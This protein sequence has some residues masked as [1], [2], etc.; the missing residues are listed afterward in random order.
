MQNKHEHIRK[1][2]IF[3]FPPGHLYLSFIFFIFFHPGL[4]L[5]L[6][7]SERIRNVLLDFIPVLDEISA[8]CDMNSQQE[9]LEYNDKQVHKMQRKILKPL[10]HLLE[11]VVVK[12]FEVCDPITGIYKLLFSL[13]Y[14]FFYYIAGPPTSFMQK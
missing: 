14:F 6:D 11:A 13:F 10:Q 2:L 1:I 9:K 5:V 7:D 12:T 3:F 4:Q 8:V